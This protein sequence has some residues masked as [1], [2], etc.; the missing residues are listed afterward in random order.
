[1]R[2]QR[3]AQP[4][5]R[6]AGQ[7]WLL[8]ASASRFPR[9]CGRLRDRNETRVTTSPLFPTF[10]HLAGRKVLLVGGG[11]IAFAKFGALKA[12][13]ARVTVVAPDVLP[14]LQARA[15]ELAL[16]P[17]AEADLDGAWFVVAA[18]PPEVNRR[19]QAAA[20]GRQLFVNAVDDPQAATAYSGAVVRRGPLTVA[21]STGGGAP[22]LA[23]LVRE[24]LEALLPDEA[25]L[26]RWGQVARQARASWKREGL[27]MSERRPRLLEALNRLYQEKRP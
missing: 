13:D 24:G 11:P 14:A 2:H 16:R 15:D 4:A 23:G 21:I 3:G 10:L 26:D 22:A 20:A 7:G 18:A 8:Y 17:F 12:A 5:R 6:L 19:V 27:P 9:E 1:M 25:E